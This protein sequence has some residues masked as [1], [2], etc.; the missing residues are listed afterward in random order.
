[1][2][3]SRFLIKAT[4]VL[5]FIPSVSNAQFVK[6]FQWDFSGGALKAASKVIPTVEGGTHEIGD[7]I[8]LMGSTNIW[9]NVNR[10][11]SAGINFGLMSNVLFEGD[12]YS[13]DV[14][15][16]GF[17]GG[18]SAKYNFFDK[19]SIKAY[20]FTNLNFNIHSASIASYYRVYSDGSYTIK[21]YDRD[22]DFFGSLGGDFG[23]GLS[24]F[25]SKGF[26]MNFTLGYQNNCF[27][28]GPAANLGFFIAF[29][30]G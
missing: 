29:I 18:F 14:S 10:K 13:P 22:E 27:Y 4:L 15:Y 1:M 17:S 7:G 28:K 11:I 9:Y 20:G 16:V 12:D 3:Y 6:K 30:N 8:V 5:F 21:Y 19:K 26:G 2:K 23:V 24:T 25:F